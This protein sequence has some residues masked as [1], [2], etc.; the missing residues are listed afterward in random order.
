MFYYACCMGRFGSVLLLNQQN[1]GNRNMCSKSYRYERI[2]P[3]KTREVALKLETRY[4]HRC[5]VLSC[6]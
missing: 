1:T 2:F 4:P 6:I 3:R 5:C